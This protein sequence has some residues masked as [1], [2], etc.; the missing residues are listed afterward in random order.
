MRASVSRRQCLA[1]L[2]LILSLPMRG[3]ALSEIARVPDDYA[4]IAEA[5]DSVPAGSIVEVSG[6]IYQEALRIDQ[7]VTLRGAAPGEALIIANADEPVIEIRD[8]E[9]VT[10]AGLTIRGGEYGIFV[11]RSRGIIIRDNVV[12]DS[13]LVGIKVRLGS[14]DIRG[15]TVF[16]ARPPYGMGIHVTNT[17]AWQASTVVGNTV[18]DNARSGVYTNMTGMIEIADNIVRDNGEHG[19]AVTEMSHAD[20]FDNIVDGNADSGIYLLDMSIARICDNIISETLGEAEAHVR[21]GN[22]IMVDFHSQAALSGNMVQGSAQ[23]GISVLYGSYA[24]L[25]ENDISGSAD[26]AVFADE[27]ALYEAAGCE[28]GD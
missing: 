1:L 14:A 24:W 6:G 21:R 7:P 18:V 25:H 23:H 2:L 8:T 5:L 9:A 20:V 4:T 12:S 3:L 22:G 16:H 15:N 27:S 13:R 26:Q 28:A 11:T 10:I 17:M 19:I